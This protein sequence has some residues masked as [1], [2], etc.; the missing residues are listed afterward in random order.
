MVDD[1]P[2]L[3]VSP[4]SEVSGNRMAIK[5][6]YVPLGESENFNFSANVKH[7]VPNPFGDLAKR[8][9][10]SSAPGVTAL[11]LLIQV[12]IAI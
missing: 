7:I 3:S 1:S 6:G 12:L 4:A 2:T 5:S 9:R 8:I 10:S 11:T